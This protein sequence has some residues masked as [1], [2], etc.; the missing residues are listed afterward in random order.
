M[1]IVA[2]AIKNGKKRQRRQPSYHG[3]Q[4]QLQLIFNEQDVRPQFNLANATS[5]PARK[6]S[7]FQRAVSSTVSFNSRTD[8][9]AH[10]K[11]GEVLTIA[12]D[13]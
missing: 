13:S 1:R 2:L 9:S 3:A 6:Q 11:G 5:N 10:L 12:T 8:G 4:H 7:T